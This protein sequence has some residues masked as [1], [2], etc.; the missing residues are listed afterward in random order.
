MTL[1]V[2]R[3]PKA[4]SVDYQAFRQEIR[5]GD[6]LL[7]SGSGLF[8][9]MIQ[10]ATGSVWSHVGFVMRLDSIDRVM[11]LESLEPLGVR[12]VPL[13]KYL[14]D[15]DSKGTP[16]PGGI[17]IARH[18]AFEQIAQQEKQAALRKLGQFAVD[19]FGYPYDSVEIARIAARIA[20][21][22]LPF[23]GADRR[24]LKRD[25]EFICSEYVWECYN[26]LGI[27]VN[28]DEKGFVAPVDFAKEKDVK[29]EAVLKKRS[30]HPHA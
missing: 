30:E 23:N 1:A 4:I 9:R 13:S 6:L 28:Y 22:H 18:A 3:F 15:Y 10:A 17:A 5:S 19:L 21:S 11:V 8:S 27:H 2:K 12:T 25:R 20:A 26:A 29:L 16:Y 7:C 14:Y 24:A